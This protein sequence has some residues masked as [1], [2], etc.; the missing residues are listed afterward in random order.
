MANPFSSYRYIPAEG[1]VK[2]NIHLNR[3]KEDLKSLL[4]ILAPLKSI[5]VSNPPNGSTLNQD[6]ADKLAKK[7][8]LLDL[9]IYF[10]YIC[11]SNDKYIYF[12]PIS[13]RE[14]NHRLNNTIEFQEF[15][16]YL[17]NAQTESLNDLEEYLRNSDKH[18]ESDEENKPNKRTSSSTSRP[19]INPNRDR[20]QAHNKETLET[21]ESFK[22]SLVTKYN[23]V[24][25]Q[26]FILRRLALLVFKNTYPDS[27][28]AGDDNLNTAIENKIRFLKEK[29]TQTSVPRTDEV[30][31]NCLIRS[32]FHQQQAL[33]ILQHDRPDF[34]KPV[35]NTLANSS[36]NNS[37]L[38]LKHHWRLLKKY[39]S[40]TNSAN[41]CLREGD[42]WKHVQH[43]IPAIQQ[44]RAT[45]ENA[46]MNQTTLS[47]IHRLLISEISN[48]MGPQAPVKIEMISSVLC[49]L[50][51]DAIGSL[52]IAAVKNLVTLN[53]E[54]QSDSFRKDA[55]NAL[56][57]TCPICLTTVPRNQ[58]ETMFLCDHMCCLECLKIYYQNTIREIE[59]HKSLNR[60]TCF[61]EAHE[62]TNDTKMNFFTYL[63]AKFRQWFS[64]DPEILKIYQDKIFY[65][66]RD[67]QFRK[68]GNPK[69]VSYFD[70]DKNN[71]IGSVR[72]PH[73]RFSQCRQCNRKWFPDHS[74]MQ[75]DEYDEWLTDNDPDDPSVQALNL[76]RETGFQCPNSACQNIF[77]LEPGGCEHFI[78]KY[79]KTDFCRMCSSLFYSLEKNK[80][81]PKVGCNPKMGFHAHCP[82]N[83]FRETRNARMNVIIKLLEDHRVNILNEL[84]KK[85]ISNDNT[86]PLE[87]CINP[88]SGVAERRLC[89]ECYKLFLCSL[90]WQ[91]QIEP[92]V[93]YE[94]NH[95]EQFLKKASVPIPANATRQVL[96]E[97]CQQNLNQSLGKPKRLTKPRF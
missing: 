87:G 67:K 62:L 8:E 47:M 59:D 54:I 65:A 74:Q 70:I 24:P 52:N 13:D 33:D 18:N 7:P 32:R 84:R 34:T 92:W 41:K 58:M 29:D 55:I 64:D 40:D 63:E 44:L 69:C 50:S 36:I 60:L 19:V 10:G 76:I 88:V 91:H 89:E 16:E 82:P 23:A 25:T 42:K 46:N 68:C 14:K 80:K 51:L 48:V 53:K 45:N 20:V 30:Y 21:V 35:S 39:Q 12:S 83:C 26:T 31:I 4:K 1:I 17:K 5:L 81:C 90:V 85:E 72:C 75:C 71:D 57:T 86:C 49:E 79:C 77:D 28:A 93:L 6:I 27:I 66:T 9:L 37:V 56:S 15:Y 43:I 94:Q 38:S 78:C 11:D 96:I 2:S 61:S 97:L 95:L 22:A 3:T 73:C